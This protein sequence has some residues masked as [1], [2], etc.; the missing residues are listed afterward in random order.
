MRKSSEQHSS[1][2]AMLAQPAGRKAPSCGGLSDGDWTKWIEWNGLLSDYSA[3]SGSPARPRWT[4]IQSGRFSRTVFSFQSRKLGK[5]EW[6]LCWRATYR[7][8]HSWM[9][10]TFG[11]IMLNLTSQCEIDASQGGQQVHVTAH[12]GGMAASPIEVSDRGPV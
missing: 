9:S 6:M 2:I 11:Q 1:L 7:R 10:S 8:T 4:P 12:R 5:Q 3:L